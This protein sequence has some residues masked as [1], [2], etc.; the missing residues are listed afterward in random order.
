MKLTAAPQNFQVPLLMTILLTLPI[1]LIIYL[2]VNILWLIATIGVLVLISVAMH[3]L[4]TFIFVLFAVKPFI[5]LTVNLKWL[6]FAGKDLS[7]L[8]MVGGFLF[9]ALI[10]YYIKYGHRYKI[11]NKK[12]ILVFLLLIVM[13]S[14]YKIFIWKSPI[15]SSVAFTLRL[16]DAYLMYFVLAHL[17]KDDSRLSSLMR[18]IWFSTV[19][20]SFVSIILFFSGSYNVD[21][22]KGV[23]R[24][25]GYYNDP[26]SPAYLA[27]ISLVFGTIYIEKRKKQG[28]TI[29]FFLRLTYLTT[30]FN[31]MFMLYITLTKSAM[32]MALIFFVLWWGWYKRRTVIILPLL[33]AGLMLAYTNIDSF[34]SRVAPEVEFLASGEYTLDSALS[35][36]MGR[37]SRWRRLRNLYL[38]FYGPYQWLFGA[39]GNF[40]AHN[41]YIAYLLQIGLVG[42]SVFLV[43]IFRFARR[44]LYLHRRYKKP[45]LFMGFTLLM[46]FVF[47]ATTGQPFD[48]TTLLWYLMIFLSLINIDY[49]NRRHSRNENH[50]S[51]TSLS[52]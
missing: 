36:G 7:A 28:K 38:Y 27:V 31:L 51:D 18:V 50:I 1:S 26:G 19:T 12:L 5:D 34:R 49:S 47:Y 21:V 44:L 3:S 32:L 33:F 52:V 13:S 40:G 30:I 6:S 39:G 46:V 35:L 17:T 15:I 23:E 24:F 41:Q 25:A 22:S 9:V 48:Y 2:K 42:L 43:I 20:L 29:P 16:L 11:Y 14:L 8:D 37:V 45:E 4:E 10:F